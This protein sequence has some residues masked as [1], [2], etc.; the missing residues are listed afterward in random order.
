MATTTPTAA[1]A[2]QRSLLEFGSEPVQLHACPC[3]LNKTTR[4]PEDI[5]AEV[6]AERARKAEQRAIRAN[7]RRL[8]NIEKDR[9]FMETHVQVPKQSSKT[10]KWHGTE[11]IPKVMLATSW[12]IPS[13]VYDRIASKFEFNKDAGCDLM[14]YRFKWARPVLDVDRETGTS[15]LRTKA[16]FYTLWDLLISAFVA[17][18]EVPLLKPATT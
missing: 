15:E 10:G 12:M 8:V 9:L 3:C 6:E 16:E 4:R 11:W 5:I 7:E 13:H 1:P 17:L 18:P 2:R 14:T